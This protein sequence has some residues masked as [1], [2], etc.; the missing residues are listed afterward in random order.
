MYK[1]AMISDIHFGVRN[2]SEI[3]SDIMEK[4]FIETLPKVLNE[5]KIKD[6]RILGDVVEYRNTVNIR[7]LNIVLKIFRWY[8]EEMPHVK[9]K[10]LKG[11]HDIY[12]HNRLDINF[13]E[14]LREFNNVEII[15][16]VT[17]E[18]INGKTVITYPWLIKGSEAD[19]KFKSV[20]ETDELY[21]LCLGHFEIN[22]FEMQ[23]GTECT[24]GVDKGLFKNY[25][26]V[27]T[28][29]FHIRNT[30][31]DGK[32]TYLGCPYPLDWGDY[33][34]PKGIHIYDLDSA[35]T[36]FIE[37]T[38]SPQFIKITVDDIVSK[39]KD[40]IKLVKGNFVCLVIDRKIKESALIKLQSKLED[41]NPIKFEVDNQ[42]I[43][44]FEGVVDNVEMEKLSDAVGFLTE[45]VENF[46]FD[47]EQNIK[48]SKINELM[49][50]LYAKVKTD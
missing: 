28:G 13:L 19:V 11:N 15:D 50:E 6:L 32:I 42:Y 25:K 35:E 43:E 26:R 29:H 30:S 41:M 20:H 24:E 47:Q 9:I 38:I 36:T 4:F 22:G 46:E 27:F 39:N 10:I 12:Y 34:N 8:A 14:V 40:K 7:T 16:K 49:K 17:E 33:G 23:K 18:N 5:H 21:D 37:N 48:K 44:D 45:Y 1:I 3:Y 2:N 31:K